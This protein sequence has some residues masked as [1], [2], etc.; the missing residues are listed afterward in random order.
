MTSSKL[1]IQHS[2]MR[3]CL[4]MYNHSRQLGMVRQ[5]SPAFAGSGNYYEPMQRSKSSAIHTATWQLGT[6]EWTRT[7][8]SSCS[9]LARSIS[10]TKNHAVPLATCLYFLLSGID[11]LANIPDR[12]TL[13]QVQTALENG[14]F[15][16]DTLARPVEGILRSCWAKNLAA[17]GN[18][19]SSLVFSHVGE[20]IRQA[21]DIKDDSDSTHGVAS[22]QLT[23]NSIGGIEVRGLDHTRVAPDPCQY[24]L[25]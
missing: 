11:P 13:R 20:A 18:V 8:T 1:A 17:I 21:L 5:S 22:D 7:T 25:I 3:L 16:I 23:D 10:T 14:T 12:K 24:D 2:S 4:N 9:T 15:A 6:W 19:D